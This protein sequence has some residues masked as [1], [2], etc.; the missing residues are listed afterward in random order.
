M[1]KGILFSVVIALLAS[2]CTL[3]DE[4]IEIIF[5]R[6]IEGFTGHI[7]N[8]SSRTMAD[9][10][11]RS[12]QMYWHEDDQVAITD[13]QS[14]AKFDLTAGEGTIDG[15][16]A[17]NAESEGTTFTEGASLYCVVPY[18]AA[19]F[20][21]QATPPQLPDLDK[22]AGDEWGDATRAGGG[23]LSIV[24]PSVQTFTGVEQSND[25]DRN[26]M[27]GTSADGGESFTF[28]QV[29]SLVRF[30]I[31]LPSEQT[32]YSAKITT[33]DA[34]IAGRTIID[35][36]S[37]SILEAQSKEL[38]LHYENPVE[39]KT[40]DGWAI[41]APVDWTKVEG[42]VWYEIVTSEGVYTFCKKPAKRF[43]VGMIYNLPLATAKFTLKE[44]VTAADLADGEYTFDKNPITVAQLRAT[45]STVAIAWTITAANT[46]IGNPA[47]VDTND[48]TADK[49]KTY[50]VA[51]YRDAACTDL[52]VSVDGIVGSSI[53]ATYA[54]RFV[55][56]ALEPST[57][58][59]AKVWNVTDSVESRPLKVATVA[60]VASAADVVTENA[61][62]S[63]MI[64]FNNFAKL[65]YAA[66]ASVNA[67]GASYRKPKELT[68]VQPVEGELTFSD[69]AYYVV[70]GG[71]EHGL[72]NNFPDANV[73]DGLGMA[74]WGWIGGKVGATGG[75]V[76]MRSGY[77]KIGTGSNNASVC[78]PALTAIPEGKYAR[79]KV[80]F[81]AAPLEKKIAVKALSAAELNADY[82]MSYSALCDQ[83]NVELSGSTSYDWE[84]C[85]VT[86]KDLPHGGCIAFGGNAA[87][88]TSCRFQLD[89]VRVTVEEIYDLEGVVTGTVLYS[90]STPAAGVVVS[91]GFSVA[92]TDSK[93]RYSLKT[94]EDTYYIYYSVP[95]DCEV[96]QNAYNQPAFFTKYSSEKSVYNFELKKLAGGAEE[97]FSLF[98]LADPQV[99]S[100]ANYNASYPEIEYFRNETVLA[101]NT[102]IAT[103]KGEGMPC[104]GVVLGDIVYSEYNGRYPQDAPN[105]VHLMDDMRDEMK[106]I[107]IPLFQTIGNHDYTY[108]G[109]DDKES[110][111]NY[112]GSNFQ[113][114]TQRAFEEVFGPI[115]YS[116]NR[117]DA[118]IINMRNI[119]F[120]D[121]AETDNDAG[122]YVMGFTD[123]QY[124]WL[125]NDLQFVP[126]DKLIIFCVHIPVWNKS[127]A[128]YPNGAN[129][130][131][132]LRRYPNLRILSGHNHYM[133]Y[134]ECYTNVK[135][136]TLAA[137][138]G[139]W[140][141]SKTN[142]DGAP[143]GYGV[144][145]INGTA[146]DN[147]YYMSSN[148]ADDVA[149]RNN[150]IRLYRG[151]LKCGKTFSIL[152]FSSSDYYELKHGEGVILAN[153]FNGCYDAGW[154]VKIYENDTPYDM[155]YITDVGDVGDV[156]AKFYSK[157]ENL[158]KKIYKI[159]VPSSYKSVAAPTDSNQDW[160]AIG[161]RVCMKNLRGDGSFV[162]CFHMYKHTIVDTS[163]TIRVEATDPYGR[164]YVQTDILENG[165]DI[166]ASIER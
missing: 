121:K 30:S 122:E 47:G 94:C 42:R 113:I 97:Q 132:L 153:V 27:V 56:P 160:W 89:D 159:D 154:T 68:E 147:Y 4:T 164:T 112:S 93:G 63:D 133:R 64:L 117:G 65:V 38:T 43:E 156:T 111:N 48:F 144:F 109:P 148:G 66:D 123:E 26:I 12:I 46:D 138:C 128:K 137:V 101:V 102:H 75:S 7:D 129:V 151:N 162:N 106:N 35:T 62:A 76:C 83:V 135:E 130:I 34:F 124:E 28:K 114:K 72:F 143:N 126:L 110:I 92:R 100:G 59:Y 158:E 52:V 55:F 50:K 155:E 22:E 73:I 24:I 33:E 25:L 77:L 61:K 91:D 119:Y 51:L 16:F 39:Q 105:T 118:H 67:A 5:G 165:D 44:G 125:K 45:D 87:P 40:T 15:T 41:L 116:W 21:Q 96:A 149:R 79:V 150:Q 58:Y 70:H 90:D 29:A 11:G 69:D 152:G 141:S 103:R 57:T 8:P 71:Q 32:I 127:D 85:E 142:G 1:K 54:P 115:N 120:T 136:H 98:V 163:A 18:M 9:D 2:A 139:A 20:E 19:D 53:Y 108:F 14:I 86:L 13:C 60:S 36:K 99:R 104:Y 146:V 81:K 37:V 3:A 166:Y 74:G 140:W 6:K 157:T 134:R 82:T 84:E 161:Y 31:T 17:I 95:A 10:Q 107:S 80:R 49:D 131:N 23:V 78:T 145:D 88:T